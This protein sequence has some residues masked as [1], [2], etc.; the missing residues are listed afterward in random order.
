MLTCALVSLYDV[1][2]LGDV[3]GEVLGDVPSEIWRL[4][5]ELRGSLAQGEI[6]L[7][8]SCHRRER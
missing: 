5:S 8:S 6:V 3:L 4:K 2:V 7:K 1:D